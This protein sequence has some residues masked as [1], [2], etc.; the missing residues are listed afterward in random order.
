MVRILDEYAELKVSTIKIKD[1]ITFLAL[2]GSSR[3]SN[4]YIIYDVTTVG[5]QK[6]NPRERYT[7]YKFITDFASSGIKLN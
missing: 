2:E 3:L 5:Q 1:V 7:G 6:P 4:L